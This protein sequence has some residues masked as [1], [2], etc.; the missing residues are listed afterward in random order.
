MRVSTDKPSTKMVEER[1]IKLENR[2]Q[3][4]IQNEAQKDRDFRGC[5]FLY[6]ILDTRTKDDKI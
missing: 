3:E 6:E 2:T 4:F 1:I 5:F